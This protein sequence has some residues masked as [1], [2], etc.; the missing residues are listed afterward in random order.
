MED[1]KK[2]RRPR[3]NFTDEFKAEAARLVIEEENPV[4]KVASDLDLT[5]SSLDKWVRQA[6][7][8][9]GKGRPGVL[10]SPEKEELAKLRKENREL[11]MEREILR[12]I[13]P[14]PAIC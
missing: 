4:A 12:N 14:S 6:R 5:R 11:R 3:R 9:D 7:A 2:A 10:T 8:D 13:G 1:G